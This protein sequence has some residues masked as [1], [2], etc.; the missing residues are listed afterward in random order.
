MIS[1][2]IGVL[3]GEQGRCC[4]DFLKD[5]GA[6]VSLKYAKDCAILGGKWCDSPGAA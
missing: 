6:S 2:T 1:S 3:G 5:E 4:G